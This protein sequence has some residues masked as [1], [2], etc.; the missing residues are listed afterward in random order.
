MALLNPDILK[1]DWLEERKVIAHVVMLHKDEQRDGHH[2]VVDSTI[3]H[4]WNT[5]YT[6]VP[7]EKTF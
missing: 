3:D 4:V 7:V 1:R 2:I 5:E 6:G